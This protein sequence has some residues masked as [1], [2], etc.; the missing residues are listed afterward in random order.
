MI[1]RI[2]HGRTPAAL[3]DDY[4][5]FLQR[6][7][8]PDYASTPGNL[9]VWVLRSVQARTA[10][11]LLITLWE[12]V[13]SIQR[14][15]GKDYRRARYYAEDEGYLLEFEENASHYEVLLGPQL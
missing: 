3:A 14:F 15:A 6:T 8:V 11:F 4:Y 12:S 10:H 9:A 1:A 13:E 2:W 5:A 7:G